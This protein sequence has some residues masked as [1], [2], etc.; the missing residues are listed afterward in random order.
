MLVVDQ[1]RTA[2]RLTGLKRLRRSDLV[3]R[4]RLQRHHAEQVE[5]AVAQRSRART[6]HPVLRLPGG[7]VA[8]LPIL[9]I[10]SEEGA[11]GAGP[12]PPIGSGTRIQMML[13]LAS[14]RCL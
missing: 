13:M 11:C 10:D 9:D 12:R 3:Q 14:I 6:H 8:E 5:S 1:R 2:I 4:E 7:E